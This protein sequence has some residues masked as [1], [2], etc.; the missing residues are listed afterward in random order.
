MS[1]VS[2]LRNTF[3]GGVFS[4]LAE[5]RVDIERYPGSMR[6]L[7]N[8]ICS[9]Q[10]PA[11]RRSGTQMM[12]PIYDEA[13]MS[14]LLPFIFSEEQ[15]NVLEF[16]DLRMRI[17]ND[18][19][20]QTY[21]PVAITAVT[22]VSPMIITAAGLAAAVG[23]QVAL[24]AFPANFSIEGTVAKVTAVAGN[25]YTLDIVYP[26]VVGAVTGPTAGRVYHIVTPY[27]QA[28]VENIRY[29]QQLEVVYLFC[30]GYR[31]YRLSRKGAYNWTLE[32]IDFIDGPYM[33][34]ADRNGTRLTPNVRG[35]T[36]PVMT[37]YSTPA[38]WTVVDSG[39]RDSL[40]GWRA[41]DGDPYDTNWRPSTDQT[42]SLEI[43]LPTPRVFNGY[44]INIGAVNSDTDY[45]NKDRA[46]ANFKLE[47]YD[48]TNYVLLDQQNEYSEWTGRRSVLIEFNN[49]VAY[50]RYRLTVNALLRNGT[51]SM[52]ISNLAFRDKT[53]AEITFTASAIT[54]INGDEGF[55][56]TDV[57]RLLRIK[58][59]DQ[60]WRPMRITAVT[61]S[62]V[63]KAVSLHDPLPDTQPILQWR[64]GHWSDTTGWPV[65][66]V[67]FEDRLWMGGSKEVPDLIAGS[68]TGAYEDFTQ[69]NPDGSVDD[70]NAV[71]FRCTHRRMSRIRW[72]ANDDRGLLIGTGTTVFT[73]RAPDNQAGL[74]AVNIKARSTTNRG[75][76]DTDVVQVD[77]QILGIHQSGRSVRE[78][79]FVYEVDGYRAPSMS[80]YASHLGVPG[81]SRIVFQSEPHSIAWVMREDGSMTGLTYNRE[82]SVIGWHT[83]DFAGAKVLSMTVVPSVDNN[84]Q[85]LLWLITERVVNGATRRYVERMQPFFDF[86]DT[87]DTAHYADCALRYKGP[88]TGTIYNLGHLEGREVIG[89]VN[90]VKFK[91]TVSGKKVDLPYLPDGA[92]NINVLI[93]LAY[94]SLGETSAFEVG[95][96]DGTALGKSKDLNNVVP[97]VWQSLGGQIGKYQEDRDIDDDTLPVVSW[98]DIQ[99]REDYSVMEQPKLFTG[100]TARQTL[101]SGGGRRASLLFR[102]IDPYPLN[103]VALLPVDNVKDG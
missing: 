4:P 80:L 51:I 66:G 92:G 35:S 31:P 90:G 72:L 8:Y 82:E 83:H 52:R 26:G 103:M 34:V 25:N 53:P 75:W 22:Q 89:L 48:G 11:I 60:R 20:I 55:K 1:R 5:G 19:G 63:V 102:Q 73:V 76:A 59:S 46:P 30:Y 47:G 45:S 65:C 98:D 88:K 38:G 18:N 43:Q 28:D 21:T 12:V 54:D 13:K 101:E 96:A 70:N 39:V 67:F 100:F 44:V 42:G 29:A 27:A 56:S 77:A 61:S 62:T 91:A 10:G 79:A 64:L 49:N 57:G 87:L 85:D 71:V 9:P 86:G 84:K 99:Y 3:N 16:G 24:S 6:Q 32:A 58:G 14:A 40:F 33:P 78:L 95:A 74:T 7:K 94:E 15:A 37:G 68:R 2:P 17:F 36:I 50:S 23:D 81:F 69:Q 93:G 41:F 97:M